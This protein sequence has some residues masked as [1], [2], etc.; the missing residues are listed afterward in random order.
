MRVLGRG[1]GFTLIELLIVVAIIALLVSILLPTLAKARELTMATMCL[2]HLKGVANSVT[3]YTLDYDMLPP[4]RETIVNPGQYTGP[5]GVTYSDAYRFALLT[6]WFKSGPYSD[7]AR[8]GDGFLGPY[9][10]TSSGGLANVLTCPSVP[11]VPEPKEVFRYGVPRTLWTSPYQGFALNLNARDIKVDKVR[12]A[13]EFVYMCDGPA[14]AVY[15]FPETDGYAKPWEY[16][17]WSPA[18]RH[19]DGNNFNMAFCDGHADGGTLRDY[20]QARYF[21]ANQGK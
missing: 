14:T 21:E 20:Y 11:E 9:A 19:S 12:Q 17:E 5:D 2:S 13:A 6:C 16:T 18:A 1:Q 10:G 7:P 8:D 3:M 15:I 4:Y